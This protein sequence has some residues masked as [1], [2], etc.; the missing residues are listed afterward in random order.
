MNA[1]ALSPDHDRDILAGIMAYDFSEIESKWQ[2]YWL[3]N[4]TFAALDPQD[5]GGMPKAYVLDMFPYPSGQGLHVG[6]PEGYT[7]T[8]IV[9]RYLRMKG[10]NV[11]HPMGWDAFGLPAEQYAI[12]NNVHPRQTTRENID[13]FRRQIQSLGLSYDWDREV[14]TTD[15]KYYRW[16]Q[17]IFL[18][19]FNSYFDP[20]NQKAMPIE[21][22]RREL[23]NQNYVVTP[24]NEV[25]INPTTEGMEQLGGEVRVERLWGE[26]S[27]SE[28]QQ[29]IDAQRL[30]YMDEVPVNWC[31]GLGTVLS[32]EEVVDGKSEVGGF[33]VERRPMRQWMLRITAYA[34]RLIKDL[35]L[36]QW[37]ESLKE[38]Q[39]NWI[40][41]SEGAEVDFELA[42]EAASAKPAAD[43]PGEPG[44][45]TPVI[46]VFTTRP[47]TLYGAT[48]MVL[49]PEHPL[50]E[51]IT[52]T[53][54][55][56]AVDDYRKAV[57]A[58]SERDR[59]TVTKDKSGV[60]T[61]AYA[62]N[63]INN[64]KI[65]VYIADYVLMG[66][67][68]GA[69]MAVPAHD[70]RDF[71][72]A[73]KFSLPIK[74]VVQPIVSAIAPI[75]GDQNPNRNDS[76][77]TPEKAFEGEGVAIGS[78]LI[79]G[80][81][82]QQAKQ[83]IIKALQADGAGQ[84][85]VRYKLRDWLFSRQRYWGEPFPILLDEQGNA[86][87]LDESELPL[88]LPEMD[89][90]KPTGTP[91]PPLSKAA[92]WT[93][94]QRNGQVFTRETNTMP[95]WA[96]SCWYY[97]RYIDPANEQRFVDK[98]KERYWM[99]VDLYVGGVEHAVLHLL[100]ARFWHKVLFDLGHVSSA[101]P[102]ARL[103][104]QGLILGET[105]FHFFEH[106]GGKPVSVNEIADIH[107][108][109]T[110]RGVRLCGTHKPTG[111]KVYATSVFDA[112][113]EKKGQDY[114]LRSDPS[115]KVDA[116]AFKMSKSR[117]NVVNP[118]Q[119]VEEYGADA[120]RLYEMYMGPLEAQKPWNTRDIVGMTRFLSSVHRNITGDEESNRVVEIVD[121]P[122][123]EGLERL[124]HRTIKKVGQDIEALHFNTG[125]A[126]LIKLNN[127][128]TGLT[129]MPRELAENFVLML[130]P[131]APHLAEELWSFLGHSK[132]LARRPWPTFDPDRMVEASVEVPVQ[133]NGKLRDRITIA[134]DADEAAVF[135]A[136]ESSPKIKPWIEGKQVK[137]RLYVPG[138]LVN[139]VVQ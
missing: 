74:P 17:W 137:K 10:V 36:L 118:D 136:A 108:E 37:P 45:E 9:S 25:V 21:H 102:F 18:Q 103:I 51:Q 55:K 114:V 26:L 32:N 3:D 52:T 98:E 50:V 8:D 132:S 130:A 129:K 80:Q 40:G 82:T 33:A 78:P 48:Y 43:E 22:L 117:G 106:E 11:L 73:R 47:D 107:E 111:E 92:S 101:E 124:M 6:H 7:A 53:E 83:T 12:K 4:R 133:I 120:F 109:A 123:A 34:D 81:P 99:P 56:Q 75:A 46:T 5:A 14:D 91:E 19:L 24:D 28:Q 27:P 2:K 63:P 121:E 30:T 95:Q 134:V 44:D 49:A 16:T 38:M 139:M 39:R 85:S 86:H 77:Q 115:I 68:T 69:I 116:R 71:D 97:L 131:F 126:E 138:R 70:Q 29:L 122:V 54:Q 112:L 125:I 59:L 13:N 76:T 67:G 72:F 84:R 105:E 100:Y 65:P 57:A 20:I 66:Y 58:R 127:E 64:E 113:V 31:Q 96:G 104:N 61:G 87:A 15:P 88:T 42:G 94:V 35:D 110:K 128:M 23:M 1:V 119:I 79:D 62:V 135:A 93:R 89:D 60:A 41:R 90:F